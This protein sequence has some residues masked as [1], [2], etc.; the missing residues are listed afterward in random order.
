MKLLKII[1]TLTLGVMI[2]LTGC[3]NTTKL[4]DTLPIGTFAIDN[5]STHIANLVTHQMLPNDDTISVMITNV[6]QEKELLL[7]RNVAGLLVKKGYA[8]ETVLPKEMRQK[9]DIS[10]M[11][12]HGVKLFIDLLPLNET[13]YYKL[14]IV[15]SGIKYYRMYALRDGMLVPVTPWSQAS[16]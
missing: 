9:G 8:V 2:T 1:G 14:E 5:L 7:A 15:L 3:K 12:A 16:L 11:A 13:E 4:A 6:N 10:E